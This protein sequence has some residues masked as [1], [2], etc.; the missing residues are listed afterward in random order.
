MDR[1]GRGWT[2]AVLVFLV[3]AIASARDAAGGENDQRDD[4][5]PAAARQTV[6]L[7]ALK[8]RDPQYLHGVLMPLGVQ[9]SPDVQ[10]N[11]LLVI[12]LP[13]EIKQVE[14]LVRELDV[15]IERTQ[16][17]PQLEL[18]LYR[19]RHR[20]PSDLMQCLIPMLSGRGRISA[21]PGSRSLLV[22]DE[23]TVH[24]DVSMIIREI[25]APLNELAA[26]KSV[27][28]PAAMAP[29]QSDAG[30]SPFPSYVAERPHENSPRAVKLRVRVCEV[31]RAA[32]DGWDDESGS[33]SDNALFREIRGGSSL[34][35]AFGSDAVDACVAEM[36]ERGLLKVVCAP[37]ITVRSGCPATFL[38]CIDEF[39]SPVVIEEDSSTEATTR[40]A[41]LVVDLKFVPTVDDEGQVRLRMSAPF[42]SPQRA[43]ASDSGT[44]TEETCPTENDFVEL[45]NYAVFAARGRITVRK[46]AE[47]GRNGLGSVPVLGQ[48]LRPKRSVM[49]ETE[50]IV[51]AAAEVD[52]SHDPERVAR[53]PN[54]VEPMSR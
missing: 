39:E 13:D 2:A 19:L 22:K 8:F 5:T 49:Q 33:I 51:F 20:Q 32:L 29:G 23:P 35:A 52:D 54:R 34:H 3:G 46:P 14:D 4:S 31:N 27:E 1:D 43:V 28:E 40:V 24:T 30:D 50:V 44:S 16:D 25:D 11:R 38:S 42:Q 10:T 37:A 48:L 12:A 9:I 26:L 47:P 6:K 41:G 7:I 18:K 45:K 53:D 17:Q 36:A 15:P 21:D